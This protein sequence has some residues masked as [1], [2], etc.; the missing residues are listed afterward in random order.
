MRK[1]LLF[2]AFALMA[3]LHVGA[4]DI[5]VVPGEPFTFDLSMDNAETI[6]AWQA[7]VVLPAGIELAERGS[8]YAVSLSDRHA[9]GSSARVVQNQE[10]KNEYTI[11]A[12]NSS[13]TPLSGNSGPVA[14]LTLLASAD[15]SGSATIQVVKQKQSTTKA[16]SLKIGDKNI[17]IV[18][19]TTAAGTTD[20]DAAGL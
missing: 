9:Q 12:F 1:T 6:C 11:I 19:D 17:N 10:R 15:F 2:V 8:S 5:K 3:T 18:A 14:T 13:L 4:Q 20:T 7:T 16:K